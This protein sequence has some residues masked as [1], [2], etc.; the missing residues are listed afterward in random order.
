MKTKRSLT[1]KKSPAKKT[2]EIER[3]KMKT[4]RNLGSTVLQ[5]V[6]VG[7][8]LYLISNAV[9]VDKDDFNIFLLDTEEDMSGRFSIRCIHISLADL[10]D[11]WGP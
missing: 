10:S 9:W 4:M 6:Q 5:L 7:G 1:V 3:S 11:S 2:N 8:L